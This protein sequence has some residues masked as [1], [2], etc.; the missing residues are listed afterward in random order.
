[1]KNKEVKQRI[2][3]IK[4]QP[5]RSWVAWHKKQ[6]HENGLLGAKARIKQIQEWTHDILKWSNNYDARRWTSWWW[7]LL[8]KD[9]YS[10]NLTSGICKSWLLIHIKL[11]VNWHGMWGVANG[12]VVMCGD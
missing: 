11:F 7:T 4:C 1:M 10:I 3:N 2:S 8:W 5:I 12:W 9:D 6:A